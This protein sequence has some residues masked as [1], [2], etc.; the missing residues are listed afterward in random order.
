MKIKNELSIEVHAF[1]KIDKKPRRGAGPR[2]PGGNRKTK[3]APGGGELL[4]DF[5]DG[6]P[7]KSLVLEIEKSVMPTRNGMD[8]IKFIPGTSMPVAHHFEFKRAANKYISAIHYN[9]EDSS[10]VK[11]LITHIDPQIKHPDT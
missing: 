2:K 11:D 8:G 1:V 10:D 9:F 4:V 3:I 7:V 5:S 6:K